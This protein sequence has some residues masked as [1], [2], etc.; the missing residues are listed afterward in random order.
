MQA[1]KRRL[2][3]KVRIGHILVYSIL[4]GGAM[5]FLLPF[6]WMFSTAVK[7]IEQTLSSSSWLPYRDYVEQKGQL[8]PV[9]NHQKV[10]VEATRIKKIKP[11]WGNFVG[12]IKAMRHFPLYLQNTLLLCFLTV[13]GMVFLVRWW[14]MGFRV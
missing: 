3:L 9:G 8:V 13:I 7:P 11:Q 2:A 14:L 6:L 10:P 1:S 12:A 4:F 5:L